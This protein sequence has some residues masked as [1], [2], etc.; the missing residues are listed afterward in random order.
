[1]TLLEVVIGYG[2]AA[3]RPAAGIPGRLYYAS[4]T[5]TFSRDNGASWDT[6][7]L[8]GAAVDAA[9]VTLA[10]AAGLTNETLFS[11]LVGR[12]AASSRPSAGTPGRLYFDTDNNV[13]QRDNGAGWD[14]VG[15]GVD[16][17]I[18]PMTAAGDLI[19]G[20]DGAIGS[21]ATAAAGA[22][23]SDG[24]GLNS[25]LNPLASAFDA[26]DGTYAGY[27]SGGPRYLRVDLGAAKTVEN[28]R[29]AQLLGSTQRV[30]DALL[31][32]STDDSSWTTLVSLGAF[33][34]DTTVTPCSPT[35]AR[36]WRLYSSGGASA[37]WA[38]HQF[39]L[40]GSTA[41]GSPSRLPV[42]SEGDVLTVISGMPGWTAPTGG[43]SD[44]PADA[45]YITTQAESG[46]SAEVLL[47]AVI[48]AGVIGSRPVAG[49]AGRLY[50]ATDTDRI[51]RDTGAGWD[52]LTLDWAAMITGKP[53]LNQIDVPTG[54]LDLGGQKITNLGTPTLATDAATKAYADAYSAASLAQHDHTG[55]ADGGV[56]TNDLHDG[57]SQYTQIAT[58]S[59]PATNSIRIYAK[60]VSGT[61]KLHMMD[62]AGTEYELPTVGSGG[63]G[64][65]ADADYVVETAHASLSAE[66]VLGSTVI[67]TTAH[68]S[69]QANAK[70]GRLH[71]PSD[72]LSIARDTG[73]AWNTWG[74]IYPLTPPPAV[75]GNLTWLNQGGAS[76]TETLDS[77]LLVVPAASGNNYRGLYRSAPATPWTLTAC[78]IPILPTANF[79][80]AG[81]F[82]RQSSDGKLAVWSLTVDG[83]SPTKPT[84]LSGK[85]TNATTYSANYTLNYPMAWGPCPL[86]LRIA[87]NGT[88]RICSW[89]PNGVDWIAFH[90]VGRTDFLTAD[91]IGF[92]ADASQTTFA[93][94]MRLISWAVA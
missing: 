33:G 80:Q 41:P 28:Y 12:G 32:Y 82:F 50:Y 69:R 3:S 94:T 4:D 83:S 2:L 18:N 60:D 31:Q 78:F 90:T 40:Y 92:G 29:V 15:E 13:M 76:A 86:W 58:P 43:G 5:L 59:A 54:S 56:L 46:L 87:D 75:S 62:E 91:Q 8:S 22:T 25:G 30:S 57:Y 74:P 17:L 21:I 23:F 67:T 79:I 42:G 73:S 11:G 19:V 61:A 9:Y 88:S 52:D 24:G 85:Y 65:P 1:M 14:D 27:N 55:S 36:Y 16:T 63:S 53:N 47:S 66:K 44:A 7:A 39:E 72:G 81:V 77:I 71:L 84:L 34:T 48:A 51:A 70:A 35:A 49:T 38:V 89:S 26:S 10:S 64:A 20:S 6:L 37:V 93:P 45:H 68:A